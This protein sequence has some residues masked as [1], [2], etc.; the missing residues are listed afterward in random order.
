M[1][2]NLVSRDGDLVH[3]NCEGNVALLSAADRGDLL[4]AVVGPDCYARTVLLDLARAEYLDSSGIS[5]LVL[6]H[7]RFLQ[8]GGRL[9][10]HSPPP[11]IRNVI[12]VLRLS[13]VLN[14]A[15]DEASARALGARE[16]A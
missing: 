10:L 14:L 13:G 6:L 16:R 9:V 8:R 3:L 1:K 4:D 2:L 5:W 12:K 15:D 11:W 7:K